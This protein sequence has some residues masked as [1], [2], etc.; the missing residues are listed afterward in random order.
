MTS[1]VTVFLKRCRD[2]H[3]VSLFLAGI[4]RPVNYVCPGLANQIQRKVHKDSAAIRLPNGKTM[5]IARDCG[6]WIATAGLLAWT[7]WP[8]ARNFSVRGSAA[9]TSQ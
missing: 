2:N 9:G 6:R 4:A 3:Y 8:R 5:Q 1:R 7:G